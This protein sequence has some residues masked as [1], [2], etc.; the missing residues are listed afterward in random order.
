MTVAPEYLARIIRQLTEE[1]AALA[2]EPRWY[3]TLATNCTSTLIQ[4]VNEI[5]PD[6]IPWHYSYV[7][8]GRTDDYLARLGYLDLASAQPISRAWLAENALR[9]SDR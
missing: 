5:E 6:A 8:T 7:L 9:S 2:T 3:H 1:T 4:Y